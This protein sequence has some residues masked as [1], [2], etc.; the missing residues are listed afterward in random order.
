MRLRQV[1]VLSLALLAFGACRKREAPPVAPPPAT[2]DAAARAREQARADSIAAAERMRREAEERERAAAAEVARA[3]ETL[4]QVIYFEYDS[5]QLTSEA[6]DRL[7]TKAGILRAN[8]SVQLRIEGHADERGSTEYN[9]ALG[10]RRAESVKNFIVGY[11]IDGGRIAT[12][13]YGEEQ[14][15]VEGTT[16]SAWSRNRRAEFEVTAGQIGTVPSEVR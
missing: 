16:E 10:Q 5:D 2:D 14:P 7:R 6:E 4:T 3:R 8:P 11:G 9:L 15:A 13:S 1:A 12:I